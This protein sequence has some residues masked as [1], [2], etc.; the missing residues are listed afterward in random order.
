MDDD[1]KKQALMQMM[2]SGKMSNAPSQP[3]MNYSDNNTPISSPGALANSYISAPLSAAIS[4]GE[5]TDVN[6]EGQLQP[7]INAAKAGWN[8]MGKDPSSAP[9]WSQTAE[10]MGISGAPASTYGLNSDANSIH[11]QPVEGSF[12]GET[13]QSP[14]PNRKGGPLDVSPADIAGSYAEMETNPLW[15]LDKSKI[16][17]ASV[18]KKL[19]LMTAEEQM[20]Q[21]GPG[22]RNLQKILYPEPKLVNDAE[23]FQ[24]LKQQLMNS[25]KKDVT[26]AGAT[27]TATDVITPKEPVSM[28]GEATP[29]DDSK[30]M[31][32][33]G[34]HI[35]PA[36]TLGD[37]MKVR[38]ALDKAGKLNFGDKIIRK[39]N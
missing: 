15:K 26:P 39:L 8:Q 21:L 27:G 1:V 6:K 18:A 19:P 23:N 16:A 37:A 20:Q 38:D 17:G 25:A 34:E 32:R 5:N 28:T 33:V 3:L 12:S 29:V 7:F 2:L 24:N 10:S 4:A 11:T 31:W 35:Y 13:Y 36:N 14:D 30:T 9:S 22:A